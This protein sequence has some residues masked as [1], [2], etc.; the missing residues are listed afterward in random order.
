MD[1]WF[2]TLWSVL[3]HVIFVICNIVCI[4]QTSN[5]T[6]SYDIL[7]EMLSLKLTQFNNEA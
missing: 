7:L 3:V 5:L 2:V 1:M 6:V 4:T